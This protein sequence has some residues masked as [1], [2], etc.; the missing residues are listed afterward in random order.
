MRVQVLKFCG[1]RAIPRSDLKNNQM[2][3][4][5]RHRSPSCRRIK[6]SLEDD[7]DFLGT[8]WHFLYF[9]KDIEKIIFTHGAMGPRFQ[10][11]ALG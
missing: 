8:L 6:I 3:I 11:S 10:I 9:V 1:P 2:E 5:F 7:C 4:I